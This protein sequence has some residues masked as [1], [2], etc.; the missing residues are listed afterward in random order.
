ML[1]LTKLTKEIL[2]AHNLEPKKYLSQNFLVDRGVYKK[3][4]KA[5]ELNTQDQV[6]EIGPG[7]G[8]LTNELVKSSGKVWAIEIDE[9]LAMALHALE[10]VTPN[11]KVV[12][13]D[14][15]QIKW[16]D[17]FDFEPNMAYKVVANIPYHLTAKI[18]KKFLTDEFKPQRMVL[19]VQKEVAERILASAGSHS[20]LS[21]SVQ[22]YGRP[23]IVSLVN[24][25]SFYPVP[26]VDSAIIKIDLLPNR[27]GTKEEEIF[28]RIA[29]IG[30]SAK[31]KKL[32]NNL[33]AGLAIDKSDL[34]KIFMD[35]SLKEGTRAQHLTLQ[36]WRDLVQRLHKK[37]FS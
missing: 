27:I 13:K 22:F 8:F 11:L 33:A 16:Q 12:N 4:I 32:I 35:L 18:I 2:K 10:S 31:R 25:R 30:F 6:I 21:L 37:Y 15:L 34:E 9:G 7:L 5:A 29:K 28:W 20:L 1:S 14:I 23:E 24:K 26:Q 17:L 36:E 3:I 19:L